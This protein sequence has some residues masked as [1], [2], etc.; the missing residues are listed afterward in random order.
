MVLVVNV[1]HYS[2]PQKK[3]RLSRI[4]KTE[5]RKEMPTKKI[6][7]ELDICFAVPTVHPEIEKVI[8]NNP[9]TIVIWDDGS[10]TVVRCQDGDT[11][12]K[13]IGLAMA[14]CKKFF[15]NK[16][17]YNEVLKKWADDFKLLSEAADEIG[18]VLTP[19]EAR[20]AE[21]VAPHKGGGEKAD[22]DQKRN[23]SRQDRCTVHS[24]PAQICQLD[25]R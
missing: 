8:Y 19:E 1:V 20:R 4:N 11:F 5:R 10:K 15:G 23:R 14:I 25:S 17:K 24:Q 16:S 6:S 18:S 12:D 7:T 22:P 2:G 9:A 3:H 13:R 21:K